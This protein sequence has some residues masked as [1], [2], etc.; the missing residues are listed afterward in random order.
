MASL[1][2]MSKEQLPPEEEQEVVEDTPVSAEQVELVTRLGIKML[3]EGGGLDT[4]GKAVQQSQDPAQVVGQF[5]VQLIGSMLDQ[6]KEQIDLDPRVFLVPDGFVDNILDFLEDQLS[7]PEE[8][9]DQVEAEVLEMIK[10]LAQGEQ[11][12][13]QQQGPGVEQAGAPPQAPAPMP[14]GPGLGGM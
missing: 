14:Q 4:L 10:A 9:S 12:P 13:Q 5:L 2:Q 7:L 3:K 11:R 8:F 6:L 1:D